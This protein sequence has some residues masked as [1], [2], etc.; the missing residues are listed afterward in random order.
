MKTQFKILIALVVVLAV[1]LF[2]QFR[3]SSKNDGLAI[4]VR[5]VKVK[6][7]QQTSQYTYLFVAEGRNKYWCAINKAQVEVGKTY[8]WRT[9][10][11]M[12]DF[13]SRELDRTFPSIFFVEDFS[14]QPILA[15]S[16]QPQMPNATTGRQMIPLKEGIAVDKAEGGITIAELFANR[17]NFSGKTVKIKGEVVKYSPGIMN[18]NWVHMQ[19]GTKDGSDFD[20]VVTTNDSVVV[21]S[22]VTAE[23]VVAVDKDFGYGYSYSV[24]V[25]EAKISK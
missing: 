3:N 4:G 1:V 7:V 13:K 25:E 16:M 20:L 14:E 11:E 10:M 24:L 2:F 23:G 18:R 6:E 19:D 22:V 8:Y 5:K 21:G 15:E 17:N 9:G 12:K